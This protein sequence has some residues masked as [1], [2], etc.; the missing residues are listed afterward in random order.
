MKI[1][2]PKAF[3]TLF[4][5]LIICLIYF[6]IQNNFIQLTHIEIHSPDIQNEIKIAHLSDLHGKEFGSNNHKL[7]SKVKDYNPDIIVFTGDLIDRSGKNIKESVSFLSELNKFRPV[8]YVPGN[9][10]HW[11]GKSELVFKLLEDNGVKVLR[12]EMGNISIKDTKIAILG[13]DETTFNNNTIDESLNK[14]ENT[15]AFKL[16]LSHYPENYSHIYKYR[17]I[18]LVLSGHAHGGQF[19]IP[20]AG[21]LYAPGQGFFPKYYKGIYTENGVNLVVSRGLG[22]SAIPVRIFNRPEIIAI[23]LKSL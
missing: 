14:L 2:R 9:H 4:A 6:Y 21:G 16:L 11:S 7:T 19:I 8:Y 5:L 23:S 13:L 18:D 15:K 20:F 10:E 17:K 12:C 1:K 3:I 22:N